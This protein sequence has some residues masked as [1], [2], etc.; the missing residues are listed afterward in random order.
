[1]K[2]VLFEDDPETGPRLRSEIEKHVPRGS[3]VV[4]ILRHPPLL[5]A[6]EDQALRGATG[7]RDEVA[8]V[9]RSDL[10]GY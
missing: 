6:Q 10:V 7:G 5:D 8:E 3:T 2:I 9:S 1:M 4:P